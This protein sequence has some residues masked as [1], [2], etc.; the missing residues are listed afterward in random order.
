M[1]EVSPTHRGDPNVPGA[2]PWFRGD[3]K[4]SNVFEVQAIFDEKK[5]AHQERI[6]KVLKVSTG[7]ASQTSPDAVLEV[8]S[9]GLEGVN[10][11]N[12]NSPVEREIRKGRCIDSR[13]RRTE[14]DKRAV[15]FGASQVRGGIVDGI[16]P[17]FLCSD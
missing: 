13:R 4:V 16:E 8:S 6:V 17:N 9:V 2:K 11:K 10:L 7:G 5:R 12:N 3:V 15:I 1:R 14:A